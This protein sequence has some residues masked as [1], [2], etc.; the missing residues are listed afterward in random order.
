MNP[1]RA[2]LTTALVLAVLVT[3]T[4]AGCVA[5]SN[6]EQSQDRAPYVPPCTW[7]LTVSVDNQYSGNLELDY[8]FIQ[9]GLLGM[10]GG[11]TKVVRPGPTTISKYGRC[12]ATSYDFRIAAYYA[13]DETHGPEQQCRFTNVNDDNITIEYVI[14][15]RRDSTGRILYPDGNTASC[16]S[17][18]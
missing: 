15:E 10:N 13:G 8:Y 9:K 6:P 11:D 14:L 3:S 12:D 17:V 16:E 7:R 4:V 18:G 2:R 5:P 1:F